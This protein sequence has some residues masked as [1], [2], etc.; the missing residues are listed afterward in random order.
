MFVMLIVCFLVNSILGTPGT[1][2]NGATPTRTGR[3]TGAGLQ[4]DEKGALPAAS[5]T[6][7]EPYDGISIAV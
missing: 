2:H 1:I 5:P 6:L 3:S 7:S 4:G